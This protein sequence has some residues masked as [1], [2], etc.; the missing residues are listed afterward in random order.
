M[1]RGKGVNLAIALPIALILAVLAVTPL[2]ASIYYLSILTD[3]LVWLALSVSWQL[4]S[5][6]T[7]YISLGSAAFFGVGWYVAAEYLDLS[8]MTSHYPVLPLPVIVLLAGLI[9][10]VLAL[11]MGFVT[12]RLR[13]I[14]FV[15]LTFAISQV[16]MAIISAYEAG[17]THTL[18]IL[19]PIFSTQ[20]TYYTMFICAFA[21]LL[22]VVLLRRSKFG[23]GL[24]MIG[25]SEEAAAHVGVNT[26]LYKI[27]GFAISAMLMGFV[28][29]CYAIST[30]YVNATIAFD[31]SYSLYPVIM[32]LLGGV[33]TI[34]GPIIGSVTISS[35]SDYLSVTLGRYFLLIL[36]LILIIIVL[37]MPDGIMGMVEKAR[38]RLS[39]WI[40]E[41][42]AKAPE[43]PP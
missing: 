41:D 34:L 43:K 13:G 14:Y 29:G 4:F 2:F 28:G 40:N 39:A 27:L 37:L 15:I 31:F 38:T 16:A 30:T 26:G 18:G 19:T 9:T 20:T 22:F 7:N 1:P 8:I 21:I 23:L 42:K 10:F 35:L 6:S 24:K 11:A 25:Q 12:L 33:G 36:G 32:T 17:I 3:M 5:G